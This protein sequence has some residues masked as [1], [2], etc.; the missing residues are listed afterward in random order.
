M[1]INWDDALVNESGQAVA[2]LAGDQNSLSVKVKFKLRLEW[3]QGNH[4]TIP[5]KIIP[6][7]ESSKSKGPKAGIHMVFWRSS[8]KT[9]T[10]KCPHSVLQVAGAQQVFDEL[11][12]SS[13]AG[14]LALHLA[15]QCSRTQWGLDLPRFFRALVCAV[16]W[17]IL[18]FS[19][20]G[21]NGPLPR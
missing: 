1:K 20:S 7:R 11:E 18:C 16:H 21:Y 2:T 14:H 5:A 3:W 9:K 19:Y 15:V 8:D 10:F 4:V 12:L 6:G 17:V 13:N